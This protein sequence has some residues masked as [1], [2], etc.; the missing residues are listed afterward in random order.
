MTQRMG[1][2]SGELATQMPAPSV[3]TSSGMGAPAPASTSSRKVVRMG[4]KTSGKVQ[5]PRRNLLT[6][7]PLPCGRD[8]RA[9]LWG[10]V[11][12]GGRGDWGRKGQ[13]ALRPPGP[14]LE[15]EAAPASPL[16]PATGE[17]GRG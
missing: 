17:R 12:G 3:G 14:H 4:Q 11:W 9:P 1:P 10:R 13:R 8:A 6:A 15:E 5:L 16:A 2:S 7:P